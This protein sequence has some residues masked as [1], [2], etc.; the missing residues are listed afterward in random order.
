MILKLSFSQI[1]SNLE[2]PGWLVA[3]VCWARRRCRWWTSAAI[4]RN[5]GSSWA[6]VLVGCLW[7]CFMVYGGNVFGA[8]LKK[9]VVK[10]IPESSHYQMVAKKGEMENGK[11]EENEN[12]G[13][14][15]LQ[16]LNSAAWI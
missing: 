4:D 14:R 11:N 2:D 1:P 9:N 16:A 12:W 13:K 15:S 6:A 10:R 8:T 3:A 7:L 5:Q